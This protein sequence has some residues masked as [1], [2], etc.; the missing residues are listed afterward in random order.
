MVELHA[1]KRPI[2]AKMAA[3]RNIYIGLFTIYRNST[4]IAKCMS[5]FIRDSTCLGTSSYRYYYYHFPS[6]NICIDIK[7]II[8]LTGWKYFLF[9]S[10]CLALTPS[11]SA[12]TT[13]CWGVVGT[14]FDSHEKADSP[15]I[16]SQ[17]K[18]WF[19]RPQ[20]MI[21]R[22]FLLFF[23]LH[24]LELSKVRTGP[25]MFCK[26]F[27]FEAQNTKMAKYSSSCQNTQIGLVQYVF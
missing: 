13:C 1:Q 10:I 2:I 26:Q 20:T 23:F 17:P 14:I 21:Y 22:E 6:L 9:K 8:R 11:G 25:G 5:N 7:T 12:R 24:D 19:S 4:F 15:S 3:N 16:I 18:S 27:D